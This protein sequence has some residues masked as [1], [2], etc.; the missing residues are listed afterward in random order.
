MKKLS[1]L[2][3]AVFLSLFMCTGCITK[4]LTHEE[5]EAV[6][7]INAQLPFG[8]EVDGNSAVSHTAVAALIEEPVDA[9]SEIVCDIVN[10]DIIQIGFLPC[11]KEGIV[12]SGKKP[13]VLIIRTGNTTTLDKTFDGKKL[14]SGFY[15]MD[16]TCG[17]KTSRIVVEVK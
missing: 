16:V 3:S 7:K 12:V 5:K 9:D 8:V 17:D 4:E 13:S 11:D 2:F 10:D 6:K 1:L 15:L 14:T